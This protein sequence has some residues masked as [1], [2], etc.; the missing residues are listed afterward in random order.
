M[1]IREQKAKLR[2]AIKER[3]ARYPA[4]K[5]TAETRSLCRRILEVLPK[6]PVTI[7]AFWPLPDEANI[8]PMLPLLLKRGNRLALPCFVQGKLT[9]RTVHDLKALVPGALGIPEPSPSA[10]PI[11]AQDIDLVLVPGRAF[12]RGGYRL[13][14]GNGGYDSWIAV[15]RTANPKTRYFGVCLECQLV[16]EVPHEEHDQRVDAIVTARGL[17]ACPSFGF[18]DSHGTLTPR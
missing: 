4:H 15:Q 10:H 16:P 5:R 11:E 3:L 8:R 2:F 1:D 14:R 12:D 13:G 6:S 7:C 17:L 9:F 18:G